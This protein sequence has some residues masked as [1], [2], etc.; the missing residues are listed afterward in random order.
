MTTYP[1]CF[2]SAAGYAMWLAVA[3]ASGDEVSP[4]DHCA[5]TFR[6]CME[7]DGRCDSV[8]VRASFTVRPKPRQQEKSQ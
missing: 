5:Q 7:R 8:A 1:P 2:E 6:Q 3:C 4:C